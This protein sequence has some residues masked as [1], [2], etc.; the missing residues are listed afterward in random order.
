MRWK[1]SF[2]SLLILL[3]FI[4]AVQAQTATATLR[5][6]VTDGGGNALP[7]TSVTLANTA[8]G[9][10]KSFTTTE[11]G[12]FTFTFIEPGFY[13][14]EAQANGFKIFRQPRLQLEV[15]QSLE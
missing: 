10:K 6:M 13:A 3:G 9:L 4:G 1:Y 14:L 11:G 12:Q 5:G 8:T 15:G 2:A 7:E